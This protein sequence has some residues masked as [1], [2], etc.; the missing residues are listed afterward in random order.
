MVDN[1][2][3]WEKI[4]AVYN[5]IFT[6]VTGIIAYYFARSNNKKD[7]IE[8]LIHQ[9]ARKACYHWMS[10]PKNPDNNLRA[11]D[12]QADLTLIALKIP[13]RKKN[14]QKVKD[15]M[16][17]FRQVATGDDFCKKNRQALS[18]SHSRMEQIRMAAENLCNAI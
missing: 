16:K 10:C 17:L 9:A 5:P 3:D 13:K 4:V 18:N 8:D 12:T 6:V 15:S 1:I 14:K 11:I 7:V 2:D